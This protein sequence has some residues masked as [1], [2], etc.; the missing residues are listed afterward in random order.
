MRKLIIF[1]V[2]KKLGLKKFEQFRFVGQKSMATY[3]F[4]ESNIMKKT[5]KGQLVSSGVSLNWLLDDECETVHI[6]KDFT[7]LRSVL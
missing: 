4:T 7:E 1:L 2:R 6:V 3:F 5:E